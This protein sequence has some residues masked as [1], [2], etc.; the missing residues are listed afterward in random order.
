MENMDEAY[1]AALS[2]NGTVL[3]QQGDRV[4]Y[5]VQLKDRIVTRIALNT[6]SGELI[7]CFPEGRV[8]NIRLLQNIR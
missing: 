3:L 7:T 5:L 8:E 4:T 6:K 1:R 2:Q